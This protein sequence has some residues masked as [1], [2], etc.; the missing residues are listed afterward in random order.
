MIQFDT[1]A[2]AAVRYD[3]PHTVLIESMTWGCPSLGLNIYYW[4]S[5]VRNLSN[6][7]MP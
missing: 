7:I 6:K 5:H 4:K 2:I 1:V 3:G